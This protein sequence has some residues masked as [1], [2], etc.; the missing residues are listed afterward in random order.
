ML[1]MLIDAM[2]STPCIHLFLFSVGR[3]LL[4]ALWSMCSVFPNWSDE[5][6]SGLAYCHLVCR[7]L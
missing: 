7:W 2:C 6:V 4:I 5:G 3:R 1:S